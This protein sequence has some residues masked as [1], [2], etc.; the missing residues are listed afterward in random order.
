ML[1]VSSSTVKLCTN[2]E[3]TITRCGK[4][5]APYNTKKQINSILNT[6]VT[7]KR[8]ALHPHIFAIN[9]DHVIKLT[10]CHI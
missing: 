9:L 7:L 1:K 6:Q 2:H 8:K 3:N 4:M 5:Q 10:I